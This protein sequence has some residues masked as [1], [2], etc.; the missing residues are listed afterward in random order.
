[1]DRCA[2]DDS[3]RVHIL[4]LHGRRDLPLHELVDWPVDGLM[5]YD[6]AGMQ[7][8]LAPLAAP[9]RHPALV[10]VGTY[11]E[12]EFDTVTLDLAAGTRAALDH[13]MA[14]GRQRIAYVAPHHFLLPAAPYVE[15]PDPRIAAY[16]AGMREA[17]REPLVV[18]LA[19]NSPSVA[20]EHMRDA[21]D[22]ARCDALFCWNDDIALGVYRGL[23]DAGVRVPDDVALVGVDGKEEAAYLDCPLSTVRLPI[24]EGCRLGWDYLSRRMVEPDIPRQEAVLV[25]ELVVRESSAG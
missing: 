19:A 2:G 14:S 17:G 20:R 10:S 15:Y 7:E 12:P 22:A 23:R 9:G 6:I 18:S 13:L 1:V 24:E 8:K 11:V 4:S 16:E 25:P 3:Y 5:L 21:F